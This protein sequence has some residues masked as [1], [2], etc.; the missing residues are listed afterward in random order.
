MGCLGGG[1]LG[2]FGGWGV[3]VVVWGAD[4]WGWVEGKW[5]VGVGPM[6]TKEICEH[7]TVFILFSFYVS[8][9]VLRRHKYTTLDFLGL[10][11]E[12]A[13]QVLLST[14]RASGPHDRLA[15]KMPSVS[16]LSGAKW[17]SV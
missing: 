9:F 13:I 12:L 10:S 4:G 17:V 1:W 3:R 11:A 8:T 15:P 16:V 5:K 2:E 7:T 14:S 6:Y